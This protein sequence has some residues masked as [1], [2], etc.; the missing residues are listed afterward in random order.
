LSL[1]GDEACFESNF[2]GRSIGDSGDSAHRERAEEAL[3]AATNARFLDSS[4]A[5][6]CAVSRRLLQARYCTAHE[7]KSLLATDDASST[8]LSERG[9]GGLRYGPLL[10]MNTVRSERCNFVS[11]SSLPRLPEAT[12]VTS[13]AG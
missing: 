9:V 8:L 6:Y 10:G 12:A 11:D 13:R 2:L 3:C 4:I 7:L 1:G 5:D